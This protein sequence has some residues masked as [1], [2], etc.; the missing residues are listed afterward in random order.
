MNR[1]QR[2]SFDRLQQLALLGELG[3]G[4]THE[5]RN[6]LT[7]IVGFAQ[8][9]RRRSDPE[10]SGRH[11]E[12]I[13]REAL[14]AVE[15]L[16]QFLLFSRADPGE[17]ESID[18][19]NVIAQVVS[20]TAAQVGMRNITIGT[21]VPTDL[22]RVR[23]RRGELTQVLLNLVINASQATPD[24]GLIDVAVT[25]GDNALDVVVTDTGTGVPVDLRERIFEPFFTTKPAGQGVGLGLALA[26]RIVTAAGGSLVCDA[27]TSGGARFVMRLPTVS[28]R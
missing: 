22:P 28:A 4:V 18:L 11:L 1:N 2:I 3:A 19:A 21:S 14:R 5:T 20:V 25:T 7:A 27:T 17:S 9:A 6:A 26:R 13:E 15:L 10:S 12:L 24:A 8:L 23:G 16:E